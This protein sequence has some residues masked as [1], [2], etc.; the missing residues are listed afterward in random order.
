MMA[1]VRRLPVPDGRHVRAARWF[2]D[3]AQDLH[4]GARSLRRTPVVAASLVVT[5]ALGIGA[6]T[7]IFSVVRGVVIRPLPFAAPER[8]VQVYGVAPLSDTDGLSAGDLSDFRRSARS[9]DGLTGYFTTTRHLHAPDGVRRLTAVSADRAFFEVLGVPAA[10]GRTFRADDPEQVAV[11]SAGL[12]DRLLGGVAAAPGAAVLL[13]GRPFTVV[14]V[15]PSEFQFPYLGATPTQS[16]LPETR[17]DVWIPDGPPVPLA[18]RRGR[19]MATARLSAGVTMAQAADELASINRRLVVERPDSVGGRGVRLVPLDAVVVPAATRRSLWLIL[20]GAGLALAAACV[21][22]ATLLL[23]RASRRARDVAIR[24]ALG[25]GRLRLI[26]QFLAE[27][28]LLSGAGALAALV[29]ARTGGRVLIALAAPLVPRAHEVSFDG[30]VFLFLAAAAIVTAVAFGL[31]PAVAAART[32][33]MATTRSSALSTTIS[34]RSRRVGNGLVAAEIAL[35]FVLAAAAAALTREAIRLGRV[36]PGV[37]VDRV[38]TLHLSPRAAERDYYEIER[39][40]RTTPGVAAAGFVQ[41]L[42]LQDWGWEAVFAIVGRPAEP[43]ER[44]PRA[45]LRYV[46]PGYFDTMGIPVLR[47]RGFTDADRA[48]APRVLVINDALARRYFPADDPIGQ[49]LTER[50]T[51]V[52]VIDDVRQA[53]LDRPSDPEIYYPIAQNTAVAPALGM[54]LAVRAEAAGPAGLLDA[55]RAVVRDVNP[56]LALFNVRTMRDV[57]SDSLWE[58]TLSRWLIGAFAGLAIV[59]AGVGVLGVMAAVAASRMREFAIRRALGSTTRGIAGLVA[60]SGTAVTGAGVV[61]GAV[62]THAGLAAIP[63]LPSSLAPGWRTS[64]LVA[65]ALGVVTQIAC[66]IPALRASSVAPV[67]VLR[68]E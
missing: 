34:P 9:L 68:E 27:S 52:G 28:L 37:S 22:V 49:E 67:T 26:R 23:V 42:P 3:A 44:R 30:G 55:V 65:A 16:A 7:A 64:L 66:L 48:D 32:S 5:L 61:A 54:S 58:L 31:L 62:L 46:T 20:G 24:A 6:T 10:A 53:H 14:G 47:G 51:I 1:M 38:L 63:Q 39:R 8:L 35:A 13:D 17:T 36:D 45:E 18:N 4:I 40:L 56:S 2:L 29:V 12:A 43:V 15:M 21:N 50:G 41:M 11:V 57:V 25:A 59:L 33:L 19:M 60:W